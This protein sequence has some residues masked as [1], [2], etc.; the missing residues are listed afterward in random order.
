MKTHS[1]KPISGCVS[2]FQVAACFSAA[3]HAAIGDGCQRDTPALRIRFNSR[4]ACSSPPLPLSKS[5]HARRQ[6][7][8]PQF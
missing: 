5:P 8:R 6:F 2:D 1:P 3:S 4:K 7:P